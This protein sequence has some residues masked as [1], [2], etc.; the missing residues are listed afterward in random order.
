MVASLFVHGATLLK[1]SLEVIQD[2]LV[3]APLAINQ[4]VLATKLNLLH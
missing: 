4:R 2:P 1:M 3:I